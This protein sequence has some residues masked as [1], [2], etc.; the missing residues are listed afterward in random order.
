M[1]DVMTTLW[2]R[3]KMGRIASE[4]SMQESCGV[5]ERRHVP[6]ALAYAAV[7]DKG[8]WGGQERET[9]QEALWAKLLDA[10]NRKVKCELEALQPT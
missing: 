5:G 9:E 10:E 6:E 4:A 8:L 1:P 3:S 7:S 2:K